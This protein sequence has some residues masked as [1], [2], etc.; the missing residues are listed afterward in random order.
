[1]QDIIITFIFLS[2]FILFF[3]WIFY[4][5]ICKRLFGIA[6]IHDYEAGLLYKNG[7]LIKKLEAGKYYFIKS[8]TEIFN[9]DLR[10]RLMTLSG[11]DILTKD[12]VNIKLTFVMS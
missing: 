12:K 2:I 3:S 6:T 10:L 1:M 11:Q 9:E 5:I 7:R 4:I 8:R